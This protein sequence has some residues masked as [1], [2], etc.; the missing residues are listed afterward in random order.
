MAESGIGKD[1]KRKFNQL[2]KVVERLI[3]KNAGS[4]LLSVTDTGTVRGKGGSDSNTNTD[5]EGRW[6]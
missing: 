2:L 4:E 6:L 3:P 1:E 5:Q